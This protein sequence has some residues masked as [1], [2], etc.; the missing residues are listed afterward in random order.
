MKYNLI[1]VEIFLSK[2]KK[3]YKLSYGELN[4]F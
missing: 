1:S 2:E 4:Y 3:K